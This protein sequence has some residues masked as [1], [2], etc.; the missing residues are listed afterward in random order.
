MYLASHTLLILPL[1]GGKFLMRTSPKSRDFCWPEIGKAISS[2][3]PLH[4][5]PSQPTFFFAHGPMGGYRSSSQG[6]YHTKT[7]GLFSFLAA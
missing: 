2:H 1:A 4:R 3:V 6:Q 7:I 5:H